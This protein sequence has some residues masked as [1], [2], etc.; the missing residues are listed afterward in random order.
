MTPSYKIQDFYFAYYG[1]P[2]DPSG[3]AFWISGVTQTGDLIGS[4]IRHFGSPT[5]PEFSQLYPPGTPIESFLTQAY[6]NLF[7][8]DPEAAGLKFWADGFR[9]WTTSGK[10]TEGEARAQILTAIVDAAN[11]QSG[12]SDNRAITNKHMVADAVTASVKQWGTEKEYITDQLDEARQLIK[13][14]DHTQISIT[15]ALSKIQYGFIAELDAPKI[16]PPTILKPSTG[17]NEGYLWLGD[18]AGKSIIVIEKASDAPFGYKFDGQGTDPAMLKLAAFKPGISKIDISAFNINADYS[19]DIIKFKSL[20]W[21]TTD[22]YSQTTPKPYKTYEG[23]F[24]DSSIIAQDFFPGDPAQH[25]Q[26][27][28]DA[29]KNGNLDPDQDLWISL[30]GVPQSAFQSS[31]F[32]F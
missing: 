17:P 30:S 32:I 11:G 2:A 15:S 3:L 12:T 6:Q 28:I 4:A 25:L 9:A 14:V 5:T 1:R 8:R 10:Y 26:I 23:F 16:I 29:N 27:V 20:P 19:S 7:N 18:I 31:D 22:W 13:N 24:N 21:Q